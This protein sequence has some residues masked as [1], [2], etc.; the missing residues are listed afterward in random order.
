MITTKISTFLLL[1][2]QTI[3][4][5]PQNIVVNLD[6]DSDTENSTQNAQI[7]SDF[8][9]DQNLQNN[10]QDQDQ[11]DIANPI[12]MH[13][14]LYQVHMQLS[15]RLPDVFP[16]R[17]NKNLPWPARSYLFRHGCY[18]FGGPTR[19]GVAGPRKTYHGP[20]ISELDGL[21]YQLYRSQ[22]CLKQDY[23][24]GILGKNSGSI[25][26]VEEDCDIEEGYPFAVFKDGSTQCGVKKDPT[27]A[28]DPANQCKMRNCE[29][30]RSFVDKVVELINS[31]WEK[32][33]ELE[34][35]IYDNKYLD[36]CPIGNEPQG[37]LNKR[38]KCC[39]TGFSRMPYNT[40]TTE[41]CDDGSH[42]EIGQC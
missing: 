39:G 22:N 10:D 26:E 6:T 31:G 20:P 15:G 14:H 7:I 28:L 17:A 1:S 5:I 30:E 12:N 41:C 9:L 33:K 24:E 11:I 18:C 13:R 36:F 23:E 3:L 42:K 27:W 16:I 21:C 38:H 34:D 19:K 40:V 2:I 8:L 4:S 32:P 37:V 35:K 25:N 29:L